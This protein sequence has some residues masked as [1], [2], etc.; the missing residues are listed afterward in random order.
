[1]VMI[2]RV[3]V[4]LL[5][6]GW[7]IARLLLG[8]I[9]PRNVERTTAVAGLGEAEGGGGFVVVGV[10]VAAADQ[11]LLAGHEVQDEC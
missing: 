1:M 11:L 9:G 5:F 7:R 2:F 4:T 8:G 6:R 3:R 10:N